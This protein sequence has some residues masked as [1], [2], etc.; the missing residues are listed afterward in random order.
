[1][2]ECP[3]PTLKGSGTI[4]G[5]F[6]EALIQTTAIDLIYLRSLSKN[7]TEERNELKRIR[8]KIN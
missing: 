8:I 6:I 7:T 2:R 4:R 5:V 3:L 1:M